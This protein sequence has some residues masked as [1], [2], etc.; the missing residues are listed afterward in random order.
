MKRTILCSAFTVAAIAAAVATQSAYA[1]RAPKA[2]MI[3][4]AGD[5]CTTDTG[6]SG[7]MVS[8]GF[9]LVCVEAT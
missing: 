6:R 7:Y 8:T 5:P 9:G 4:D 1:V 2:V 3:V